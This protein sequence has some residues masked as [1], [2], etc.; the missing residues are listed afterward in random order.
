MRTSPI[1]SQPEP[2]T[3]SDSEQAAALFGPSNA[4]AALCLQVRRLAPHLRT[5]L[6]TGAQNCGQEAVARML[7]M[8]SPSPHRPFVTLA[9]SNAEQYLS[10][11]AAAGEMPSV[12]LFL[13]D[14]D[15]F[16]ILAQKQLFSLLKGRRSNRVMIV[17]AATEDLR[18][19][20]GGRR[21]LPEVTAALGEVCIQVPALKERR[22]D[23]PMLLNQVISLRCQAKQK[24]APKLS[25]GFLH[26]A[27]RHN[28]PG[29]LAE[30]SRI[31]EH[32]LGTETKAV[33]D[34]SAW[35]RALK[36]LHYSGS[37]PCGTELVRLDTLIQQHVSAVLEACEGNKMRAAQILG[38]S[39][40]TLY[41]TLED[42]KKQSRLH[43]V[44]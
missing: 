14:I 4:V 15:R 23:L 12:L 41:R 9:S 2:N 22:E 29:N 31:V 37:Q 17:A 16:S 3:F 44:Q 27:S 5:V 35:K 10:G 34:V 40:S 7:L 33:L 39:R 30:F 19:L 32:L 11:I 18:K 42:G 24:A 25:E 13:P 21:Y 38:V 6:L 20:V 1:S 26:A 36:A 28:W 43:L 8:F